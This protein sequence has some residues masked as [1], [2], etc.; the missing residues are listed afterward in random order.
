MVAVSRR[1]NGSSKPKTLDNEN[2]GIR[3]ITLTEYI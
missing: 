1:R 3:E 2:Q